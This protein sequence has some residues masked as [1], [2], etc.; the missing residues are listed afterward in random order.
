VVDKIGLQANMKR[1][2]SGAS[3]NAQSHDP[4]RTQ[5]ANS[6]GKPFSVPGDTSGDR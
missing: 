1:G 3:T 4:A 5:C 6:R 2:H